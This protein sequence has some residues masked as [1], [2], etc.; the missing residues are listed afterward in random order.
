MQSA[1]GKWL[2]TH[3]H[4]LAPRPQALFDELMV[5]KSCLVNFFD[6]GARNPQEQHELKSDA[7]RI[8][9]FAVSSTVFRENG[10]Q[11][12]ARGS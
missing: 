7:S 1:G 2:C 3:T 12:Q 9:A 11:W 10:S 4:L 8:S 5:H 6:V